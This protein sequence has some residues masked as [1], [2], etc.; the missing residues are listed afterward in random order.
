MPLL[1]THLF[2][3]ATVVLETWLQQPPEDVHAFFAAVEPKNRIVPDV[4]VPS[5][6]GL[7]LLQD[8][9]LELPPLPHL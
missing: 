7:H 2:P 8:E 5:D 4:Y 6:E 9:L 3:L 1:M